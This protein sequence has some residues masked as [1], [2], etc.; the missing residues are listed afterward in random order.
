M[1]KFDLSLIQDSKRVGWPYTWGMMSFENPVGAVSVG[2]D[3]AF[4]GD[5]DLTRDLLQ[6]RRTWETLYVQLGHLVVVQLLDD[7]GGD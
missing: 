6:A 5:L 7:Q 2:D 3:M 4:P 1:L